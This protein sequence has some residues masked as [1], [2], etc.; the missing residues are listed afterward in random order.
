VPN[1]DAVKDN[2]DTC[3]SD[4]ANDCVQGCDGIWGSGV[5]NDNCGISILS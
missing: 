1:G 4:A 5:G 3:D 2:C